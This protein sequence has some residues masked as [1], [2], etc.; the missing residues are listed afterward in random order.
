MR[1][2]D[3]EEDG[4]ENTAAGAGTAGGEGAGSSSLPFLRDMHRQHILKV[5]KDTE[6]LDYLVT[7]H[8]RLSGVYWGLMGMSLLGYD[9]MDEMGGEGELVEW[10]MSCRSPKNGG[11]GGSPGH[12]PHILYTLSALQCLALMNHLERVDKDEVASYIAGLQQPDGS[13]WGDEW[14]E[15]DTRFSYCALSA[16]ALINRLDCGEIDVDKAVEFIAS[17]QNFDGGFGCV[18]GAESHAGQIFT[19]VGALSIAHRLDIVDVD[20]LGWWLASRQCDSGGLNGRPE[21]QADV[22]YSWWILSALSILGRVDWLDRKH[23]TKFILEC[24]DDEEGG[25]AERPGNCS[26][27]FHTFFGVA[28]LCLLGYLKAEEGGYRQVDPVY[29]L[30]EE[31]VEQLGLKSQCLEIPNARRR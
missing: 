16:M 18:P 2:R 9:I 30:P 28:G 17:C 31:L 4:Q 12:D 11:F 25:I 7:E 15:V 26:D 21:K 10:V 5:S 24:Q 6:S 1:G 3:L 13:F 22:C 19:C 27:I 29:A 20:L 14:G 8:L 23:L